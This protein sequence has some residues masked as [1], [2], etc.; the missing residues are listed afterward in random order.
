MRARAV[1]KSGRAA[2]VSSVRRAA[3]GRARAVGTAKGARRTSSAAAGAG[4]GASSRVPLVRSHGTDAGRVIGKSSDECYTP[5][6]FVRLARDV[7][8][9][10]DLDPAS[11]A[12]A[13]AVVRAGRYFD[14][15]RNG[16]KRKWRGRVW[17]NC[18]YSAPAPWVG[19]L[20]AH[21]Q[22]G[23]VSAA[24]ALFNSRTGSR[25]F[26]EL[27]GVAWRCEARKRIRFY[28]PGTS[29][30]NGMLDQV[31]FYLGDNPARF[32]AVFSAVGRIVA[33]SVT[34]AVTGARPCVVCGRALAGLR[35][36]AETCSS[37]CRQS[38]YRRGSS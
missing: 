4:A 11:S 13:Q 1:K 19:A 6:E 38:R 33:P 30:G 26:H 25:W 37:R 9:V 32:S 12:Q 34:Q 21:Y 10:I 35:R 31:F 2:V 22:S 17:L 18:P 23:A 14:K 20:L 16:L 36:D 8:G 27:A 5:A 3:R 7:L 15:E 29:G 28:G 24:V